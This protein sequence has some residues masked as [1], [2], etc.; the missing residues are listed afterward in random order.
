MVAHVIANGG[1]QEALKL[2][3]LAAK[4]LSLVAA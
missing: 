2:N 4:V 3:S 1:T